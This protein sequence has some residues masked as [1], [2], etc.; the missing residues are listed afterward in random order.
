VSRRPPPHAAG[1]AADE[2]LHDAGV[3]ILPNSYRV[4]PSF[5]DQFGNYLLDGVPDAEDFP[6]DWVRDYTGTNWPELSSITGGGT[7]YSGVLVDYVTPPGSADAF[8]QPACNGDDTP[9]EHR[10]QRYRI[11]SMTSGHGRIVQ[12]QMLHL[13]LGMA[14]HDG[15]I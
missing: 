13:L 6:D 1:A 14:F 4:W 9:I 2:D 8:P 3:L 5:K 11:G 7:A 12:Y 15:I 10:H